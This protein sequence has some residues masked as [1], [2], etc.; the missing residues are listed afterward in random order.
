MGGI[1][2]IAQLRGSEGHGCQSRL[3]NT[4]HVRSTPGYFLSSVAYKTPPR[5]KIM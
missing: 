3:V 2:S 4:S 5:F 1:L